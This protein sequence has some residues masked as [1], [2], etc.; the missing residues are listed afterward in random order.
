MNTA[1]VPI[2]ETRRAHGL[3]DHLTGT[4]VKLDG[5]LR[6]Q[7]SSVVRSNTDENDKNVVDL[8]STNS[9]SDAAV[10]TSVDL[11]A[12]G[13][14]YAATQIHTASQMVDW[15]PQHN[16]ATPRMGPQTTTQRIRW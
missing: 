2:S 7:L 9:D 5:P 12:F 4:V 3:V 13:V 15:T 14:R 10:E 1:A 16:F 6:N 8:D 11:V